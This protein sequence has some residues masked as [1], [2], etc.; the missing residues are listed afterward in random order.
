MIKLKMRSNKLSY[1]MLM[2]SNKLNFNVQMKEQIITY[3][4][5]VDYVER[6]VN[7]P[8]INNVILEGNKTLS[9]LGIVTPSVTEE[10]LIFS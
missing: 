5:E 9:E 7:K 8:S 2:R 4:G 6:V 3:G 10:N 1:N